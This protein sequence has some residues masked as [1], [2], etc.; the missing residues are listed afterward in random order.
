[1][2]RTSDI[3]LDARRGTIY[4]RNGNVLATSVDASTIYAV[5]TEVED[6]ARTAQ[7]LAEVLG[8]EVAYYQS[9]IEESEGFVYIQRKADLDKAQALQERARELYKEAS[10]KAGDS[11]AIITTPLTGIYF[12]DDWKRYY[13]YGDVG[14]QVIG[15]VGVDG[16]G[17]SGLELQYDDILSGEDGS[18][19]FESGIG[20]TPVAGGTQLVEAATDGVDIIISLDIE[21]QSYLET[22]LKDLGTSR[23]VEKGNAILVDGETGEVYAAASLP[24]Y[25]FSGDD[26][27]EGSES[28]SCIVSGYEPGSI[29]KTLTAAAALENRVTS[30]DQEYQVPPELVIHEYTITD[31]H[32]RYSTE[33]MT[34]KQIVE[35]SSNIGISMVEQQ[36]GDQAFFDFIKAC[37][38][39]EYTGI[40]YPGEANGFV[41]DVDEWS[42][43]EAATISFGQ[44]VAVTSLQMAC[45]YGAIA[46]DGIY[47]KPHF[48][49]SINTD[50]G[51]LDDET[52]KMVEELQ[53]Q[54]V[55]GQ[56]GTRIMSEGTCRDLDDILAGVVSEGTGSWARI[57]GYTAAG[58]TAAE[59]AVAEINAD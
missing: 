58:K 7:E 46:N 54:H 8:G 10:A 1:S 34:L 35:K 52:R 15:F 57:D 33:T 47:L 27:Q 56:K 45:L 13:P 17:L 16:N 50:E 26:Y 28:L 31:A 53:E 19:R 11:S 59:T 23:N 6:P 14:A 3:I 51:D 49:I 42:P 2:K 48:L 40:D 18:M 25:S 20:G 22:Q 44:S 41:K 9:L 32:D 39:G 36:V 24:L 43:M 37:C 30:S 5:S 55:K 29:F 38:I 12:Q 21:L 4:D